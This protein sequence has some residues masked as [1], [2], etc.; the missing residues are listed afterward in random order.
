MYQA[1]AGM[2]CQFFAGHTLNMIEVKNL[3]LKFHYLKLILRIPVL[4]KYWLHFI[5]ENN[6]M[7]IYLKPS[8]KRNLLFIFNVNLILFPFI[9]TKYILFIFLDI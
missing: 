7:C 3:D 1:K 9:K 2:D 6:S 4:P 8:F 5:V